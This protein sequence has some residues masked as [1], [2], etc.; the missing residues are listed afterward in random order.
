MSEKLAHVVVRNSVVDINLFNQNPQDAFVSFHFHRKVH[1]RFNFFMTKHMFYPF[2]TYTIQNKTVI[3]QLY[4]DWLLSCFFKI[5]VVPLSLI[6]NTIKWRNFAKENSVDSVKIFY[7]KIH[8]SIHICLMCVI[9][10]NIIG[11]VNR[12]YH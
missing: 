4:T 12:H 6:L 9:S 10:A 5:R 2:H 11:E 7:Y 1:A 3:T 8:L